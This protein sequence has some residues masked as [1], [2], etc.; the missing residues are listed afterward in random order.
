M[1]QTIIIRRGFPFKD[2]LTSWPRFGN[3][4]SK[5]RWGEKQD[6]SARLQL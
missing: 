1:D 2:T 4:K 5:P 3:V 6:L